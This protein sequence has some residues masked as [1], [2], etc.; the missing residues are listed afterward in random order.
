MI[1]S[2]YQ[3]NRAAFPRAELEKHRGLCIAF[4]ADGTCIIASGPSLEEADRQVR[5][6]GEDPNHAVFERVPGPEDDICLGSEE[7]ACFNSPTSKNS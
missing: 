3:S 2:A 4:S 6:A 1:S 7:F 5:A